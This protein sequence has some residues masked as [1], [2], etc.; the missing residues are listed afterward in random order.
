[1]VEALR[2]TG[3]RKR[4]VIP[5]RATQVP[6]YRLLKRPNHLRLHHRIKARGVRWPEL[7][8]ELELQTRLNQSH[9]S[10]VN[11][12]DGGGYLWRPWLKPHAVLCL[13]VTPARPGWEVSEGRIYN[14]FPRK[15]SYHLFLPE[16][17]TTTCTIV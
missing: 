8:S 11:Q 13:E 14:L 4:V 16:A 3:P 7:E 15:P 6:Q 17:Q 5:S 10:D 1:M 12:R 2:H 9:S